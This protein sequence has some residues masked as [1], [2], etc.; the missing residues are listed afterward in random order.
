MVPVS[1]LSRLSEC[2][3][4]SDTSQA[5]VFVQQ[6][7]TATFPPPPLST[8]KEAVCLWWGMGPPAVSLPCL[9]WAAEPRETNQN[10][11]SEYT[12]LQGNW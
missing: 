10:K 11:H 4:K 7:V 6:Y 1:A 9:Y 5:P 3:T 2:G 12:D 8:M